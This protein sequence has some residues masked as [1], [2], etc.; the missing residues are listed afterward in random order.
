MLDMF[1]QMR[2]SPCDFTDAKC[3]LN[4]GKNHRFRRLHRRY[5]ICEFI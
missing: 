1:I 3:T 4:Y 2:Y 5:K